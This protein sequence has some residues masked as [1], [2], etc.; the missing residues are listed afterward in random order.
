MRCLLRN[1]ERDNPPE[2]SSVKFRNIE[3]VGPRDNDSKYSI[4]SNF[5]FL[6][7]RFL[8]KSHQVYKYDPVHPHS[9]DHTSC[10]LSLASVGRQIQAHADIYTQQ[11]KQ[12][13]A[14][15]FGRLFFRL[16]V[17]RTRTSSK[18]DAEDG[19]SLNGREIPN[20][21]KEILQIDLCARQDFACEN[22]A[23]I[24]NTAVVGWCGGTS[25]GP[26]SQVESG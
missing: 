14:H 18:D 3:Q 26:I 17:R 2:S 19:Y 13:I 15:K 12:S 24:I 4:T 6:Q 11:R 22:A 8:P 21:G 16:G 9:D 23:D 25:S 7:V 5:H 1:W 20:F 10:R